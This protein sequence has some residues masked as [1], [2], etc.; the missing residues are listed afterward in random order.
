[1]STIRQPYPEEQINAASVSVCKYMKQAEESINQQ[2][3]A[4]Y[5]TAHPELVAAFIQAAASER[6]SIV[7]HDHIVPALDSI[8]AR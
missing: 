2:F 8:P 4:G 5:A 7:L 6:L 3:G 1:M